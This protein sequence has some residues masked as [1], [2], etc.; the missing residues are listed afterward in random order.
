MVEEGA[1]VSITDRDLT[2]ASL[3]STLDGLTPDR[4]RAMAKASGGAGRRDAAQQVLGVLREVVK[5]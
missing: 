3:V 2:G 5:R 1:A 4:L